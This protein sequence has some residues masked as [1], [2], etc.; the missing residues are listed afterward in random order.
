MTFS[1]AEAREFRSN[2]MQWFAAHQRDLPWRKTQDPYKIWVSEVMLQ[3]TTVRAVI[4]Y[5]ERWIEL[6]PDIQTLSRAPLE[7]VLKAW[8]GLGYYQRAKNLHQA[9]RIVVSRF[10]GKLPNTE[11][12][13]RRLPGFGPYTTAAVLSLA[14]G[15]PY[16]VLDANVRRVM[17]RLHRIKKKPGSSLDA[18]LLG[19]L[20]S[21]ISRQDPGR[22]NQA[23]ME[24][25][26][27]LCGSRNPLCL[28]CP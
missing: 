16:P 27:T 3:Q 6:F 24:L 18:E 2:L 10:G 22:F 23:L 9:A 19:T 1:E 11:P 17:M 12:E 28:L 4:P 13:L 26:A 21:L 8:E 25:G 7:R 15:Q 5:Y 20:R 14:F